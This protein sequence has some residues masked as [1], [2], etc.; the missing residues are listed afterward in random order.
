[1]TMGD[2][3]EEMMWD[4]I[5][6]SRGEVLG[7]EATV[8]QIIAAL[9]DYDAQQAR[10]AELEANIN[11]KADWIERTINDMATDAERNADLNL[12]GWITRRK[13]DVGPYADHII[14][15]V[16]IYEAEIER[17][18]NLERWKEAET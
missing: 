8:D 9:P 1:M 14:E 10:I 5:Y 12:A 7:I 6:C 2:D 17:Q 15:S 18:R 11:L 16:R 3:I 4:G 13:S